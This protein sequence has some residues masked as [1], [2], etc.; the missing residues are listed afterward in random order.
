MKATLHIDFTF[1]SIVWSPHF[2]CLNAHTS[3][4]STNQYHK[5][6]Y[7][8]FNILIGVKA[9]VDEIMIQPRGSY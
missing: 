1:I 6:K 9:Q 7:P 4:T 3:L 8:L 2:S 5:H